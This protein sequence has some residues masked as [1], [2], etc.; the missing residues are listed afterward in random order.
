GLVSPVIFLIGQFI[1]RLAAS[2]SPIFFLIVIF[3]PACIFAANLIDRRASFSVRL[4]Q[5]YAPL[6]S[7]ALYG[8]TAAHLLMTVPALA[9]YQPGGPSPQMTQAVLQLAPLP[10]F[11]F[12]MIFA[13]RAVLQLSA[14]RA[15]GAVAIGA[16]SLVA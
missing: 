11:L 8:W 10:Y 3:V 5:E 14:G 9:V 13:L 4:Q 7:C 6:L 2:A 16:C 15:L 12:L 1:S